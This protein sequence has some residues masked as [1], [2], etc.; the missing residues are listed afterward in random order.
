MRRKKDVFY[1]YE[2]DYIHDPETDALLREYSELTG[3]LF[4]DYCR[5]EWPT[6][7]DWYADLKIAVYRE[8]ANAEKAL[9]EEPEEDLVILY[10]G[11]IYSN[12]DVQ[13]LG[14]GL[15]SIRKKEEDIRIGRSM[16][17]PIYN[18]VYC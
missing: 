11:Q 9:T 4:P 7:A 1:V 8:R 2:L 3:A 16:L 13:V 18:K 6:Q 17:V 14:D 10:K 15:F 5:S 12:R